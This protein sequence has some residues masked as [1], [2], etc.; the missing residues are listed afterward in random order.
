M[1]IPAEE[2][3]DR[4][5]PAWAKWNAPPK[6]AEER[7]RELEANNEFHWR[8]VQTGA[9]PSRTRFIDAG[10]EPG[11]HTVQTRH[12]VGEWSKPEVIDTRMIEAEHQRNPPSP[13]TLRFARAALA[14]LH[15]DWRRDQRARMRSACT[16]LLRPRGRR[17]R[18]E[19]R[20]GYRRPTTSRGPP[21][22]G[23]GDDP[24]GNSDA[25]A[26]GVARAFPRPRAGTL[27][28][29]PVALDAFVEDT[30]PELYTFAEHRR[31]YSHLSPSN[32]L[33]AFLTLPE[34]QCDQAWR[35]LRFDIERER[36]P[37]AVTS[38]RP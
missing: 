15:R 21:D 29:V 23:D 14:A 7:Q 32:Q 27:R 25:L 12:G 11:T 18:S 28:H 10:P 24:D 5:G 26:P 2:P 22:D 1:P 9:Q 38:A 13:E 4:A 30:L 19:P 3:E 37:P 17:G 20:P 31:R 36:G 6:S 16:A 35:S 34:W 8:R 33:A